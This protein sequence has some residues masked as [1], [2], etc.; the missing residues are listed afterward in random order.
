MP[1]LVLYE[2]KGQHHC[3]IVVTQKGATFEVQQGHATSGKT[4]KVKAHQVL[5]NFDD[6]T[7]PDQIMLAAQAESATLDS[8]FLWEALPQAG[9]TIQAHPTGFSFLDAAHE[10]FGENCSRIQEIATLLALHRA[11]IYFSRHGGGRY[12]CSTPELLQAAKDGIARRAQQQA[13]QAQFV[14]SLLKD[15]VPPEIAAMATALLNSPDKKTL[16]YQAVMQAAKVLNLTLPQCLLRWGLIASTY[17]YHRYIFLAEMFPEGLEFPATLPA[18]TLPQDL[19]LASV[20]AFSIDDQNTTEIDDAFSVEYLP[21]GATRIGIHIAVPS[22]VM[23]PDDAYDHIAR[24][25]YS[26][27][28]APGEKITMLP[29]VLVTQFSLQEGQDIPV[30]S[31]YLEC[32]ADGS[33]GRTQS[34]LE[35][36]RILHN[37]RTNQLDSLVTLE[38]L[39]ADTPTDAYPCAAELAQLWRGAKSLYQQRQDARVSYGLTPEKGQRTE[40]HFYVE[41]VEDQAMPRINITPRLRGAPLDLIVAE[42]MIF[43]NRTWAQWLSELDVPAIFRT[44]SNFKVRMQTQSAPHHGLGVAHYFWATSPLRRYTDMVNQWQLLVAITH[45]TAAPLFAPFKAKSSTL[46]GIISG[47]EATY[48]S[49]Q[50]YQRKMENFWCLRWLQQQYDFSA[51][52]PISITAR[53]LMSDSVILEDIPLMIKIAPHTYPRDTRVRIQILTIDEIMVSVNAHLDPHHPVI[54]LDD[55]TQSVVVKTASETPILGTPTVL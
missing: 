32:A 36:V 22:V 45:G 35:R 55:V 19:P 2:E 23:T 38:S 4:Q 44:Q 15:T 51:T 29:D 39:E 24:A 26:T 28:Y 52:T 16:E 43:A 8:D 18:L 42:W 10:Y 7:A 53:V 37:L 27:L 11:P 1:S 25:R 9:L 46:F 14:E 20:G 34:K 30:M 47:F 3:A 50:Q 21:D 5:L 54:E 41:R 17:D 12:L 40:Y 48:Q 31:L 33:F 6:K 49:Y 13:I